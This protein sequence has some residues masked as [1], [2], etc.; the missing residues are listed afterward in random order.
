MKTSWQ[1]DK[2]KSRDDERKPLPNKKEA[3]L[4]YNTW[5][6]VSTGAQ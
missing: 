4:M 6:Q 1:S 2:L 3:K 5:V